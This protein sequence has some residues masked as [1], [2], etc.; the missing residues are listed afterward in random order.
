M[1]LALQLIR[2]KVS[3]EAEIAYRL[4]QSS[5]FLV[6]AGPLAVYRGYAVGVRRHC[7]RL[8]GSE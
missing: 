2:S 1:T 7:V 5:V 3:C 8:R 6:V 4:D